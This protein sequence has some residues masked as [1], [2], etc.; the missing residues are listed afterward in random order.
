MHDESIKGKA[1]ILTRK[2]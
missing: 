2:Q 1:I